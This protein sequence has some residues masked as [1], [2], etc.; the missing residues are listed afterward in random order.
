MLGPRG[1]GRLLA[2]AREVRR[3]AGLVEGVGI[4][5]DHHHHF[6]E[7]V[8]ASSE[9]S[10]VDSIL[11]AASVMAPTVP[12]PIEVGV[13]AGVI[14]PASL[15][16]VGAVSCRR[17]GGEK[18]SGRRQL[19]LCPLFTWGLEQDPPWGAFGARMLERGTRLQTCSDLSLKLGL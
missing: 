8:G 15:L 9:L 6:L 5:P 16:V 18:V 2:K 3:G 12:D 10:P 11:V 13:G 17:E 19:Y 4:G 1:G 14:P 7:R